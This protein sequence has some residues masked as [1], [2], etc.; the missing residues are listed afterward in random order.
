MP[1]WAMMLLGLT[2][3]FVVVGVCLACLLLRWL[4]K[5]RNGPD[6][7]VSV[8][9]VSVTVGQ[10]SPSNGV[11]SRGTP[12]TP[13]LQSFTIQRNRK[14]LGLLITDDNEIMRI[15]PDGGAAHSAPGLKVGDVLVTVDGVALGTRSLAD[16][17]NSMPPRKA[18]TIAVKR[19]YPT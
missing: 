14:G 7:G 1:A 12:R 6:E 5:Q 13:P 4:S 9:S 3:L 18:Y 8:Q 16:H 10:P 17:L 11:H 2:S 19:G 15:V